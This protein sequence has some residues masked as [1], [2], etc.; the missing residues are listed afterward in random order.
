MKGAKKRRRLNSKSKRM[1]KEEDDEPL[2][3][4]LCVK[5]INKLDLKRFD[6]MEEC[7]LLDFDPFHSLNQ[8]LSHSDSDSDSDVSLV[9]EKGQVACRDYPH[10]RYLCLKFPFPTTPHQTYCEMCYCYVCDAIAP[11][12][13]WTSH[14]HADQFSKRE[15]RSNSDNNHTPPP[16]L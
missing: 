2:R 12:D 10:A 8:T 3:P 14:C 15:R 11:C 13:H 1:Q 6:A 4:M 16:L 5:N 9:A 7:Y